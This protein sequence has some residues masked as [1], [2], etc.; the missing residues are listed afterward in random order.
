[1]WQDEYEYTTHVILRSQRA[2][3]NETKPI[4]IV[5]FFTQWSESRGFVRWFGMVTNESTEDRMIVV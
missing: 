4:W 3:S 1:M 5:G 2:L